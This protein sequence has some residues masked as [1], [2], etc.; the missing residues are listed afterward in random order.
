MTNSQINVLYMKKKNLVIITIPCR[1]LMEMQRAKEAVLYHLETLNP[2][3]SAQGNT[4]TVRV[5]PIDPEC[6]QPEEA[7]GIIR[8]TLAQS[9]IF[10]HGWTCQLHQQESR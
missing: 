5:I 3:F 8:Q 2:D 1:D 9:L 4:L 10:V 6:F 7:C